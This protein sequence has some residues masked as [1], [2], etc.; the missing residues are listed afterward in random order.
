[1]EAFIEVLGSRAEAQAKA[2]AKYYNTTYTVEA[3]GTCA[4][5][6]NKELEQAFCIDDNTFL[7]SIQA[8]EAA[9]S[10]YIN[11]DDISF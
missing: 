11:P 9:T 4:V 3:D 7:D 5:V 6:A 1:M 10:V 2:I 8:V